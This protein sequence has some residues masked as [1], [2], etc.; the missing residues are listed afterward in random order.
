MPDDFQY[1]IKTDTSEAVEH[2]HKLTESQRGLIDQLKILR[3]EI[4]ALG[5]IIHLVKNPFVA[6]AVGIGVVLK[7]FRDYIDKVKEAEAAS[8]A[9]NQTIAGSSNQRLVHQQMVGIMEGYAVALEKIARSG[10]TADTRMK[11]LL[12]T[13]S[14]QAKAADDTRK[15]LHTLAE[16]EIAG[17]EASGAI[18]PLEA[19]RRRIALSSTAAA[20]DRA[21]SARQ[22]S[23]ELFA[24]MGA[25]GQTQSHLFDL[26]NR[27]PGAQ[28]ALEAATNQGN[29]DA[30]R[31]QALRDEGGRL[32]QLREQ[33]KRERDFLAAVEEGRMGTKSMRADVRQKVATMEA[34]IA[35]LE[36]GLKNAAT[37]EEQAKQRTAKAA[38]ALADLN[39][40]IQADTK[41]IQE[42]TA[43]ERARM[44]SLTIQGVTMRSLGGIEA[45]TGSLR[46][47]T[48]ALGTVGSLAPQLLGLQGQI[49][50]DINAGKGIAPAIASHYGEL[51]SQL[52]QALNQVMAHHLTL[53]RTIVAQLGQMGISVQALQAQVQNHQQ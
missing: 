21:A 8:D 36:Q 19:T 27:I 25:R 18:T 4:P 22:A 24:V 38:A 11:A 5:E 40:K 23:D 34:E 52:L 3:H 6:L 46:S 16:E 32:P 50:G 42:L 2:A 37:I 47:D 10:D 48:A 39:E 26:S 49:A 12:G 28:A 44:E 7:A 31:V 30:G 20:G 29:L 53:S 15:A 17:Q 9:F 41:R 51:M 14:A 35:A 1:K 43:E 33:L 13:I 45:R